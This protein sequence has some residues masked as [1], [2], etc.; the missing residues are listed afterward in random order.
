MLEVHG[1]PY[2]AVDSDANVVAAARRDGKPA[3]FGDASRAEFLRNCGIER[4]RA[5]VVT[6]DATPKAP[7]AS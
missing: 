4:A 6:T 1:I 3:Y 7:S 5:V 2:L